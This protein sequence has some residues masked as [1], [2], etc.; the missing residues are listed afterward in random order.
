MITLVLVTSGGFLWERHRIQIS[1]GHLMRGVK[2]T[3]RR[4]NG[5][6]CLYTEGRVGGHVSA[7]SLEQYRRSD[8]FRPVSITVS[9]W[10]WVYATNLSRLQGKTSKRHVGEAHSVPTTAILLPQCLSCYWGK[11][12]SLRMLTNLR[13][14]DLSLTTAQQRFSGQN[15]PS[16]LYPHRMDMEKNRV[17]HRYRNDTLLSVCELLVILHT[18]LADC[19]ITEVVYLPVA[20]RNNSFVLPIF[21]L[22]CAIL[23]AGRTYYVSVH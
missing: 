15:L 7:L 17:S 11:T 5:Q 19:F 20:C 18:K 14:A 22:G 3:D 4:R 8:N 13:L 6:A 10:E 1:D 16:D 12:V 23:P 21:S 2:I 9:A